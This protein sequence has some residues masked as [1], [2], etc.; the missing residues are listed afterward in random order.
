MNG[1][2]IEDWE[3]E[4]I[5][6]NYQQMSDIELSNQLDR[7]NYTV[8]VLRRQ[9]N[10]FRPLSPIPFNHTEVSFILNNYQSMNNTEIATHLKRTG[11][12]ISCFLIRRGLRRV[13]RRKQTNSVYITKQVARM[14]LLIS[15]C[16][17]TQSPYK[18]DLY[19]QELK[20]LSGL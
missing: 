4:F 13:I 19:K 16:E 14:K 2:L 7:S 6:D 5:K 3:K 1:K 18:L 15:L 8:Q 9:L 10:C 17:T 11:A 20:K 12:S